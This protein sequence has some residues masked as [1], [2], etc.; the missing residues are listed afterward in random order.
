[1]APDTSIADRQLLNEALAAAPPAIRNAGPLQ[2]R[3]KPDGPQRCRLCGNRAVMT[4]EHTPPR[5]AGNRL[6]SRSHTVMEWHAR[7]GFGEWPGGKVEQ[8]GIFGYTLCGP[9]NNVTGLPKRGLSAEYAKWTQGASG[10]LSV[11]E[12]VAELNQRTESAVYETRLKEVRP[13]AFVRQVLSMMFTASGEWGLAD[14]HPDLTASVLNGTVTTFPDDMWLG[15]ALCPGPSAVVGG[16]AVK[17]DLAERS[18]RW[19]CA[20]AY[21]PFAFELTLA[22]SAMDF[23][24][25]LAGIG[26]FVE[27]H[28]SEV[29]DVELDLVVAF[30][31]SALPGEW[32]TE[33]QIAQQ[34]DLDGSDLN[35]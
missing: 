20:I 34:L 13:G 17:V 33:A 30:T 29:Y 19:L 1:M 25:G 27:V 3:S 5:T 28:E 8:G 15:M 26:G 24:S 2:P 35:R 31:H 22:A 7:D 4:R 6:T 10:I 12:R 18:W 16:P 11:P 21:P 9:C 32:R 23:R 14:K